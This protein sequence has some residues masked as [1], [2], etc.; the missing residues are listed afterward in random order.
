MVVASSSMV[1]RCAPSMIGGMVTSSIL[2]L[3]VIPVLFALV[4]GRELRGAG[5][6]AIEEGAVAPVPA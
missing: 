4:C 6:G 5:L 1:L 2:I 3:V